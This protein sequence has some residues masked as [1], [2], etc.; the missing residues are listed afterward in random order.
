MAAASV[1]ILGRIGEVVATGDINGASLGIYWNVTIL[2]TFGSE[3]FEMLKA[4]T[5]E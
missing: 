3:F 5:G 1:D 4:T 2:V